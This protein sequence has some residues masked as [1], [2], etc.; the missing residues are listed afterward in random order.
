MLADRQPRVASA[1]K[2]TTILVSFTILKFQ[3]I[4]LTLNIDI[5]SDTQKDKFI[6]IGTILVMSVKRILCTDV[7]LK[8]MKT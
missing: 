4:V 8:V 7:L 1:I 6:S 3:I 5:S 2:A